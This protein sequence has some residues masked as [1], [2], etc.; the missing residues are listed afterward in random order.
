MSDSARALIA[1]LLEQGDQIDKFDWSYDAYDPD[2]PDSI[3]YNI[4]KLTIFDGPI[5]D[6]LRELDEQGALFWEW[7]SPTAKCFLRGFS[8]Q[9]E[10]N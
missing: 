1:A 9:V 7:D 10:G 3:L 6:A 5:D 8:D 4:N 2:P